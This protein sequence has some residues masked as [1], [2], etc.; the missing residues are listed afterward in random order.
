ML[1]RSDCV[2]LLT[3]APSQSSIAGRRDAPERYTEIA[4]EFVRLK[5]N[6]IVT[7]GDAVPTLKQAT[8]I[9]PIVFVLS[10]DPVGSGLVSS[11]ARPGGNVTGLSVQATVNHIKD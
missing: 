3:V 1:L 8:A 10:N 2:R 9:I 11:L 6:V 7:T 5:V 4:T